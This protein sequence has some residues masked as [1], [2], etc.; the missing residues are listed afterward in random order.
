MP[1]DGVICLWYVDAPAIEPPERDPDNAL[2]WYEDGAN[3]TLYGQI[4]DG[5][6]YLLWQGYQTESPPN[7]GWVK[8]TEVYCEYAGGSSEYYGSCTFDATK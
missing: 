7:S 1:F 5:G 6:S 2:H 8:D 3:P 4:P